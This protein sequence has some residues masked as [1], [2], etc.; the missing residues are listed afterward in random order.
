MARMFIFDLV[1][2]TWMDRYDVEEVSGLQEGEKGRD[3][4]GAEGAWTEENFGTPSNRGEDVIVS[5]TGRV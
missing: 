5:I 3:G 2:K 1:L 4:V